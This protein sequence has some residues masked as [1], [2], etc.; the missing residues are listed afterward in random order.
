MLGGWL[1][2]QQAKQCLVLP[3]LAKFCQNSGSLTVTARGPNYQPE[4]VALARLLRDV[5]SSSTPSISAGHA[6][7]FCLVA[8]HI[9][10]PHMWCF[11]N[12]LHVQHYW[13]YSD[14]FVYRHYYLIAHCNFTCTRMMRALNCTACLSYP[15]H[16]CLDISNGPKEDWESC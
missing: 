13:H 9:P 16:M 11:S 8:K 1:P 2:F 5:G 14:T 3:R 7:P 6:M 4:F 12:T 10:E 15:I